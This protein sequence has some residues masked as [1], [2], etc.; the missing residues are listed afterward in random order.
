MIC[1]QF[2]KKRSVSISSLRSL[3]GR[4]HSETSLPTNANKSAEAAV[5]AMFAIER[6]PDIEILNYQ[7]AA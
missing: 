4:L 1:V 2:N 3:R 6:S 7:D 5:Y